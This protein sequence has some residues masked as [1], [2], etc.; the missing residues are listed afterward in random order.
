MKR[1]SAVLH[2]IDELSL[3]ANA[4]FDLGENNRKFA[5]NSAYL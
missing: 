1:S 5:P 3:E 2:F 4:E